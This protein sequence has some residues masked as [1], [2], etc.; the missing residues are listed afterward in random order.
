[1]LAAHS[2]RMTTL[3]ADLRVVADT[4]MALDAAVDLERESGAGVIVLRAR[5]AD[6]NRDYNL[7]LE[8]ILARL[9]SAGIRSIAVQIASSETRDRLG[10]AERLVRVD[11]SPVIELGRRTPAELRRLIGRWRPR[12]A[13]RQ[14]ARRASGVVEAIRRSDS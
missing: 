7:A 6:R 1:M 13:A 3:D 14:G 5:Y 8:T 11:G 4:G 10:D 2:R 12:V 9:G